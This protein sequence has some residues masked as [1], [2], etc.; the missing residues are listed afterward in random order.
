MSFILD[1]LKKAEAER[2]L[3]QVPNLHVQ[4]LGSLPAH[5]T[6]SR[7]G[8]TLLIAAFTILIAASGMLAWLRPW[9]DPASSGQDSSKASE[10]IPASRTSSPTANA[11]T[12]PVQAAAPDR[13]VIADASPLPAQNLSAHLAPAPKKP[14]APPARPAVKKSGATSAPAAAHPDARKAAELPGNPV[15]ATSTPATAAP[16]AA[17]TPLP[18][19]MA[20]A[21]PPIRQTAHAQAGSGEIEPR[22]NAALTP[23]NATPSQRELPELIQRELPSLSIGG[24]IYSENPKERQLLVNRRLVHEGE[25]AAS[26][27]L[28]EKML[29]KAAVFNYKGYRY[30]VAY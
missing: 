16:V 21:K 15:A 6:P 4:P 23:E 12:T 17:T 8:K 3:G 26:G 2:Q 29:P 13:Q 14:S 28:L 22:S 1:A 18:P 11:A 30:R 20:A 25:E 19:A 27:V 7:S 5:A 24:Y 10:D 9:Q